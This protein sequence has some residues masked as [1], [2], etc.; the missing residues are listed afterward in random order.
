MRMTTMVK[1]TAVAQYA[2]CVRSISRKSA[3][4]IPKIPDT[5]DMGKKITVVMVNT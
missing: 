1:G 4:F 2:H 5:A 3:V